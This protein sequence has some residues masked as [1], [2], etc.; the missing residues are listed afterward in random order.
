MK[1]R[2]AENDVQALM[3]RDCAFARFL[4]TI[5]Y[6]PGYICQGKSSIGAGIWRRPHPAQFGL[7]RRVLKERGVAV[8]NLIA[9]L[10]QMDQTGICMAV[11]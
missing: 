3:D 1:I 4:P 11:I 10:K 8:E 5:H 6:A 7:R 9:E 2:A